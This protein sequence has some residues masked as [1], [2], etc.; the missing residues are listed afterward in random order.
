VRPFWK[1]NPLKTTVELPDTFA[2]K[3]EFLV[4]ELKTDFQTLVSK[5]AIER[6]NNLYE[7]LSRE[8][9]GRK[10]QEEAFHILDEI[11]RD[12]MGIELEA[13]EQEQVEESHGLSLQATDHP[14]RHFDPAIPTM[15]KAN[16]VAGSC[17]LQGGK[18]C[19]YAAPVARQCAVFQLKTTK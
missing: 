18:P 4:K 14:C 16:E 5:A 10:S 13:P 3:V 15:F 17:L 8:A 2:E 7:R 19:V 6:I 1:K 11:D 9:A 12:V